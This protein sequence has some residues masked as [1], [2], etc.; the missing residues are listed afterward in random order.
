VVIDSTPVTFITNGSTI[1][2][3]EYS[4]PIPL[5][6]DRAHDYVLV[7]YIASGSADVVGQP[8]TGGAE[9]QYASGYHA[10]DTSVFVTGMSACDFYG[11]YV[12]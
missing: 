8:C 9:T 2:G 10:T 7:V 5:A 4:D 6:I 12:E 3:F 1:S 11:A